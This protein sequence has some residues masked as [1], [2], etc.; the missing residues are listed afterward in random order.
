MRSSTLRSPRGPFAVPARSLMLA[1]GILSIGFGAINLFH[2]WHLKEVD[3]LYVGVAA[4]V[5]A[6]WLVSLMLGFRGFKP[7]VVIAGAIAFLEFGIISS[8]HFVG[9][10]GG[11]ST[12]VKAEGLSMAPLLMALMVLSLLTFM[13]AI[14]SWSHPG[15]R[16]KR[17]RM[18][19]FL[20]TALLGATL[21]I[22]YATDSVQRNDF[23]TA[24]PED[25]TF[26]ASVCA[27]FWLFGGLWI[28]RA[29]KTGAILIGLAGFMAT[30]TFT[31]L[32]IVK[33]GDSIVTIAAKS[34]PGWAVIAVAMA[35]LAF[36]SLLVALGILIV[37]L[38]RQRRAAP[39]AVS[40]TPV[41]R[42]GSARP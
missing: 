11:M 14:V 6:I 30:F 7:A 27:I 17:I 33:G 25:G 35:G 10:P 19:P 26:A 38:A 2:E 41:R 31:A 39:A 16:L 24:S 22:L 36:L 9:G 3:N 18:L 37:T 23:G 8:S 29:R 15:G 13:T 12:Y 32:H 21:V 20:L 1:A 34:G 4:A 42:S 40:A 5:G 28:A